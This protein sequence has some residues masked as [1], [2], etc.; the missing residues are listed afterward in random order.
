[1]NLGNAQNHNFEHEHHYLNH[2]TCPVDLI[3]TVEA[4]WSNPAVGKIH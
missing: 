1:M 4:T 3:Y 2:D